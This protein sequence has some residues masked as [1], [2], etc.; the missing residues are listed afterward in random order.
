LPC[1][2]WFYTKRGDR[3]EHKPIEVLAGNLGA[4][5]GSKQRET[6][7]TS[8][9]AMTA[10]PESALQAERDAKDMQAYICVELNG[11][12]D[13]QGAL[14]GS[15]QLKRCRDRRHP[16]CEGGQKPLIVFTLN[17]SLFYVN[18]FRTTRCGKKLLAISDILL[19]CKE[20]APILLGPRFP[21][22]L[23]LMAQVHIVF[24]FH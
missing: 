4:F 18:W 5:T 15:W 11:L 9:K 1:P 2:H 24:L 10:L 3:K 8:A 22:V 17:Q 13:S 23:S 14:T 7:L 6:D 21:L 16:V 19:S 20:D 12:V